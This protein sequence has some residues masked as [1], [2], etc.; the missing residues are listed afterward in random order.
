MHLSFDLYPGYLRAFK[1]KP[2]TGGA[3]RLKYDLHA[4]RNYAYRTENGQRVGP[5]P[6]VRAEGSLDLEFLKANAP[7]PIRKL[8]LKH[9]R[10]WSTWTRQEHASK[11]TITADVDY[12]ANAQ[13]SPG[14]WNLS[15]QSDP[16]FPVKSYRYDALGPME[17]QGSR[18]GN[19]IEIRT[20]ASQQIR[21]YQAKHATTS[22][23]T[24]IERLYSGAVET[25]PVDY[26]DDLSMFRPGLELTPLPEQSIE[27]EGREE[28][29]HGFAL[30]G[31]AILPL[32]FW[33]NV[34][35]HVLA[36]I[37]RNVAYTLTDIE[38]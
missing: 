25:G 10:S 14:H 9:I 1:M 20:A 24:L 22:L 16:I 26:L 19:T 8:K 28:T 23:Y 31:P 7:S 11:Q 18:R 36:V 30:V 17:Q 12:A 5:F 29:L 6:Q 37:G 38:H 32:Y 4:M 13:G 21:H 35:N 3:T 34:H 15:Y 27:I 2:S 33:Q